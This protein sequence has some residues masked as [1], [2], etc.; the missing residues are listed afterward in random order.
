[1]T[2]AAKQALEQE[3]AKANID[4]VMFGAGVILI[5]ADGSVRHVS[6]SRVSIDGHKL[7]ALAVHHGDDN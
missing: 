7:P 3:L 4:A 2:D 5:L 6:F 1:M